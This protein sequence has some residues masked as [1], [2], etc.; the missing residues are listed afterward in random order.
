MMVVVVCTASVSV[1]SCWELHVHHWLVWK[2]FRF[3]VIFWWSVG[4]VSHQVAI[5]KTVIMHIAICKFLLV[6]IHFVQFWTH[7]SVGTSSSYLPSKDMSTLCSGSWLSVSTNRV[8]SAHISLVDLSN[9]L[10]LISI[11]H[12]KLFG[13][14]SI[15]RSHSLTSSCSTSLYWPLKHDL[16]L[17][18]D[19]RYLVVIFLNRRQIYINSINIL[20]I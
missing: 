9:H 17:R 12:H 19:G 4:S 16:A 10:H 14:S 20:L 3:A 8:W 1:G 6:L 11:I 5:W 13:I 2:V 18:W 15:Y 7:M